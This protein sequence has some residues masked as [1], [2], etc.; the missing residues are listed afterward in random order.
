MWKQI[1]DSY[2]NFIN[3]D[4]KVTIFMFIIG[5]IY[6]I[7][8][9]NPVTNLLIHPFDYT[10]SIGLN[11]IF[12]IIFYIIVDAIIPN[13]IFKTNMFLVPLLIVSNIYF[14]VTG[15]I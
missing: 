11:G 4:E 3:N 9:I 5:C 13:K 8:K 10:I 2:F 15:H 1:I 12:Y 14:C 6:S 7:T